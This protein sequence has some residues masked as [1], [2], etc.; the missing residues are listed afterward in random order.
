[1]LARWCVLLAAA[2]SSSAFALS[3]QPTSAV[4]VAKT[5]YS[6]EAAVVEEMS[7]KV[8]FENSG[9]FTREQ[10]SRVRILTDAGVKDWGLLSFPY[11]SASQKVEASRDPENLDALIDDFGDRSGPDPAREPDV[12]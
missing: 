3:E 12:E 6:Q 2:V 5:D 9:N 1:M 4:A 8:V 7:T 10:V 11:Q